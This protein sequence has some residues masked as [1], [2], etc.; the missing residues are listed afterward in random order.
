[1][2]MLPRFPL[3]HLLYSAVAV[4]LCVSLVACDD[5][6]D[7]A[8][9]QEPLTIVDFVES[10]G[11]LSTL[12]QALETAELRETLSGEGPY[13]LFA[14]ENA[15]FEELNGDELL[16]NDSLLAEALRYHIVPSALFPQDFSDGQ[17]LETLQGD[18]LTVSIRG[19]TLRIDDAIALGVAQTDNGLAYVVDAVLIP[20]TQ[21][22]TTD[23]D[24]TATSSAF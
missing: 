2:N 20:P 4:V 7:P 23:Q 1:M 9:P 13:T 16:Q 24:T 19:D 21:Q 18:E 22:D 11:A 15:A 17:P 12:A 10:Q 6:D 5:D 3:R 14:P 8:A